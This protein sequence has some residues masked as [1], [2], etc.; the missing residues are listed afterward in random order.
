MATLLEGM[1]AHNVTAGILEEARTK[2]LLAVVPRGESKP[3]ELRERLR[4]WEAGHF[5]ALLDR[6]H[7]QKRETARVVWPAEERAARR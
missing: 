2:L 6:V 7:S 5:G 1:N 4:L 3:R